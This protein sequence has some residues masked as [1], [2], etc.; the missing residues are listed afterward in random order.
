MFDENLEV[1]EEN[2]WTKIVSMDDKIKEIE[3]RIDNLEDFDE[4]W[5]MT[6]E[7]KDE[8]RL[9]RN[10]LKASEEYKEKIEQEVEK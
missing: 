2:T 4:N 6:C 1:K 10:L 7:E 3:D 9:L 5:V 8:L